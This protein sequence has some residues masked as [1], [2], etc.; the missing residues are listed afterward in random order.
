MDISP[1][2]QEVLNREGIPGE[3][4]GTTYLTRKSIDWA[5][6]VICMTHA[7]TDGIISRFPLAQNKTRPI[8]HYIN[9]SAD[10]PDPFGGDVEVYKDCF[11]KIRECIDSLVTRLKES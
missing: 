3:F 1:N 4:G 11:H 2:A 6:M 5:D 10:L 8:L 9:S 7:H